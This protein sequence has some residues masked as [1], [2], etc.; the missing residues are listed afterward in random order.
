M[1]RVTQH[2]VIQQP[3]QETVIHSESQV[4]EAEKPIPVVEMPL[5]IHNFITPTIIDK[6]ISPPTPLLVEIVP[7]T[8]TE[9][10]TEFEALVQ[11]HRIDS[12]EKITHVESSVVAPVESVVKKAE[13]LIVPDE[14]ILP[15]L[16]KTVINES[17]GRHL[18]FGDLVDGETLPPSDKKWNPAQGNKTVRWFDMQWKSDGNYV[19]VNWCVFATHMELE[20]KKL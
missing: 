16:E 5:A 3:E 6:T 17:A 14:V 11:Q 9:I 4:I 10:I 12:Y 15:V 19:L 1:G 13:E 8:I 20:L 18:T 2:Q 7:S